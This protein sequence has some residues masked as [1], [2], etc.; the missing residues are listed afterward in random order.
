MLR[1][2][3]GSSLVTVAILAQPGTA[4]GHRVFRANRATVPPLTL[5]RAYSESAI[6]ARDSPG[7]SCAA[8]DTESFTASEYTDDSDWQQSR[9]QPQSR[10]RGQAAGPTARPTLPVSLGGHRGQDH[11]LYRR[12]T[13]KGL[14]LAGPGPSPPEPGWPA[15]GPPRLARGPVEPVTVPVTASVIMIPDLSRRGR[16]DGLGRT[17]KFIQENSRKCLQKIESV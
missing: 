10:G 9:A 16:L 17:G 7:P 12:R 3:S 5:L 4:C 13:W 6:R 1:L 15:S 11:P 2:A 8:S 14:C